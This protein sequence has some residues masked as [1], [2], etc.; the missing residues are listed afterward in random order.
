MF[1]SAIVVL[2]LLIL[3][4]TGV[5]N[6][7][8]CP[9][10]CNWSL[11]IWIHNKRRCNARWFK[12]QRNGVSLI[13]DSTRQVC[14]S[15]PARPHLKPKTRVGRFW[16]NTSLLIWMEI[17][18]RTFILNITISV[19]SVSLFLIKLTICTS[20]ILLCMWIVNAFLIEERHSK[21]LQNQV[22][23]ISV[24]SSFFVS[25]SARSNASISAGL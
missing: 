10:R 25:P 4:L 14:N 13:V 5:S 16:Q 24:S 3:L 11:Y 19:S 23:F 22:A 21:G 2:R 9:W 7:R 15:Q 18:G 20:H 8:C 1:V 17:N 12:W 6:F